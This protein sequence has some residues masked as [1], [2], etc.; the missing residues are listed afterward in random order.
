[1]DG[2]FLYHVVVVE[3]E[4]EVVRERGDLVDQHRQDRLGGGRVGRVERGQNF[5]PNP[6]PQPLQ[7]G[8]EVGQK[9][10]GM[11]V[12]FVQRNPGDRQLAL[13]APFAEHG[14]LA[15][16]GRRRDEGQLALYPL[17]QLLGQAPTYHQVGAEGWD[18]KLG[19]QERIPERCAVWTVLR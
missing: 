16:T 15:E 11:V 1:V 9:T 3:D 19:R 13:Q 2:S 10:G 17:V 7:G 8:Y 5:L 14:G 6:F 18:A 4:R 12:P